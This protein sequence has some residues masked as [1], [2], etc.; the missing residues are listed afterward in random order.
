MFVS[1]SG[2]SRPGGSSATVALPDTTPRPTVDEALRESEERFR[3]LFYGHSACKLIIDPGTGGIVDANE[4]AARFY[5]WSTDQLRTMRIQQINTLSAEAV[6]RAMAMA[7]A[8]GKSSFEFLHRL[9]DGSIRDVEVFSNRVETGGG[10]VLYSIVHDI[11][12]RKRIERERR[13]AEGALR[14]TTVLLQHA[15]AVARMGHWEFSL[16]DQV[17]HASPGAA[18][19]YGFAESVISL[20]AV[21]S[22]ALAEY[23]PY[24]DAALKDLVERGGLYDTEFKIRNATTG[25]IVDVHSRA[26]FDSTSR[27][28]FGIVQDISERKRVEVEREKLIL[29]LESAIEHVKTLK[30]IVPICAS[31]KKIRDDPGFWEQVEAYV[32]RHTEAQ[33]SHGLCPGCIETL[34]PDLAPLFKSDSGKTPQ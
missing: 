14:Q 20:I 4:A 16:D 6:E 23:R 25:Q 34:Y 26:E 10:S 31:C 7:A 24:L 32:S 12:D 22:C 5:G 13:E 1:T 33:F 3:L 19:I 28:V 2:S 17:M 18:R 15:E 9:A 8:S 30:G 21:R 11:S 27:K 29:Q